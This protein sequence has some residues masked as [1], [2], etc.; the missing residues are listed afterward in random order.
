MKNICAGDQN[1]ILEVRQA[2]ALFSASDYV[3]YKK[4]TSIN[5]G[6]HK[7]NASK[8][9]GSR[10]RTPVGH[11]V[12][13]LLHWETDEDTGDNSAPTEPSPKVARLFPKKEE[14]KTPLELRN[15]TANIN[16]FNVRAL[17]T[18]KA[19]K[20]SCSPVTVTNIYSSSDC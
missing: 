15:G 18:R 11:L 12:K 9:C 1:R 5:G 16:N 14:E 2:A 8:C 6:W 3:S 4:Y 13:T 19:N 7:Q 17:L 20:Q 10:L